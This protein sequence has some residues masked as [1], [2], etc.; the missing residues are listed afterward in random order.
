[1]AS[2]MTLVK[3]ALRKTSDT[4]DDEIRLYIDAAVKDLEIAG[5]NPVDT[6]DPIVQTAIVTYVKIH[7]GQPGDADRLKSSYDEQKA[8]LRTATGYTEWGD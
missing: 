7:F 4:F 1:M 3:T 6:S 5:I 8:Q 2:I